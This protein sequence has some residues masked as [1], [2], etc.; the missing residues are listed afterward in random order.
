MTLATKAQKVT[1]TAAAPSTSKSGSRVASASAVIGALSAKLSGPTGVL[2]TITADNLSSKASFTA[3]RGGGTTPIASTSIGKLLIN[4]P[5][6][7]I[8]NVTLSASKPAANKVLFHTLDGS[9]VIWANRQTVTTSAGKAAAI[10]VNA[11]EVQ[12]SKVKY[13][14]KVLTT[15]FVIGTSFAK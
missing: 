13:Q 14:G 3:V 10:N 12:L 2:M 15:D 4:A 5:A 6:L 8:K 9:I 7:G 11:V 1:S